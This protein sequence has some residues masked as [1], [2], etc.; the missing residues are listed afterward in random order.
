MAKLLKKQ[1]LVANDPWQVVADDQEINDFSIISFQRWQQNKSELAAKAQEGLLGIW[2]DSSETADLLE[3]DVNRF[4]LIAVNFPVFTD[5]RGYSTARLLRERHGFK[6]E[7]RA[8]GD[9]LIDQL[10]LLDRI[11]FDALALREDQDLERALNAFKPFSYAYQSDVN[12][13]RP[14]WRRRP[15]TASVQTSNH[16]VETALEA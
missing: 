11:G 2:L 5:G 6:G 1:Q 15:T 8:I 13:P 14:L 12:D 3:E 10:F 4:A 9:V 7:L 16:T